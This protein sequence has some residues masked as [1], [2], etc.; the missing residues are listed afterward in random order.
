M[1]LDPYDPDYPAQ[2]FAHDHSVARTV[3]HAAEG[4]VLGMLARRYRWIR[5]TVAL[6][7][8]FCVLLMLGIIVFNVVNYGSIA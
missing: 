4:Y 1:D 2:K 6:V 3:E 7:V 5:I 8:T